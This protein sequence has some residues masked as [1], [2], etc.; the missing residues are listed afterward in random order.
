MQQL[1]AE[2]DIRINCEKQLQ[3]TKKELQKKENE[4]SEQRH[5]IQQ[6]QM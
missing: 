1:A 2:K 5:I 4:T 3:Q 6:L